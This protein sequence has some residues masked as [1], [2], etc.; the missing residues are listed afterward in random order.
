MTIAG[1]AGRPES[2]PYLTRRRSH[3]PG[4]ERVFKYMMVGP[5][6]LWVVALT[7]FPLFEVL[8]YS[9]A[10]YVLGLGITH[11]VGL[12]NYAE[13]LESARFWHSI[14]VTVIYVL[15]TVP[16]EVVFGFLLAWLVN[17]HAPGTKF[18]RMLITA[19][20]FTMEVAI[21]YLGIT[22]FSAQG[23]LVTSLLRLVGISIPWLS[24]A[25]WGLTA[26][27]ILEVWRW[28]PF[29]FL[30]A[31]AALA[32]IPDEIYDAAVIDCE[33][34]WQVMRH[35]AVPLA[36]PVMTI[37]VLFRLIEGFKAF[38]LPFALTGGGPGTSTQL[39]S[40]YDYLTTVEFFNFGKGSAMSIVMLAML[41]VVIVLFFG[42]MRRRIG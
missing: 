34:H 35:V 13:V 25:T 27:M 4:D 33:S 17:L 29:V 39:F 30:L 32:A 18:F 22:M 40:I 16:I 6:V 7:L 24:T 2:A 38:G 1:A 20:L 37:A 41:S 23:G 28:T 9:F 14:L 12:G 26:A 31:L 21:G 42:Q 3:G 11:Y 15:L 10:D 5:A 36:W 19:P 8:R